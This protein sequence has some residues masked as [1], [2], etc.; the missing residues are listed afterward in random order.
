MMN[1]SLPDHIDTLLLGYLCLIQRLLE[2]FF[3]QM[4]EH[5]KEIVSFCNEIIQSN[6]KKQLTFK[7]IE[8]LY[9]IYSVKGNIRNEVTFFIII[10]FVI[11]KSYY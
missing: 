11:F 3:P 1:C 2:E 7:A 4:K 5:D 6:I 9:V 8:I 10:I